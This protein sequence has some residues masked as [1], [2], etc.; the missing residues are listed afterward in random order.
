MNPISQPYA[1][2]IAAAKAAGYSDRE[3]QSFLSQR[4]PRQAMPAPTPPQ[5]QPTRGRGGT[6][7]SLISEGGALSGAALGAS[8]GSAVPIAGTAIGGII[9][10]GVGA[11]GGRIAENKVRDDR[12]GIGDAAK[13]GALSAVLAGPLRLAKYGTT[14]AKAAKSGAGLSQALAAGAD[15]AANFSIRAALGRGAAESGK[16]LA[17]RPLGLAKGQKT[18]VRQLGRGNVADLADKYGIKSFDDIGKTIAAQNDRYGQ[19][20]ES[21][22]AIP[23]K[24]IASSFGE[25]LKKLSG[26]KSTANKTLAQSLKAETDNILKQLPDTID[27]PTLNTIKREFDGLLTPAA[28]MANPAQ[29]NLNK[30]IADA[31]RKGIQKASGSDELR[32]TGLDLR[33][34][35]KLKD[36]ASKNLEAGTGKSGLRLTDIIFG[37]AAVANPAALAGVAGARALSSP[38]AAKVTSTGLKKTGQKLAEK[39]AQAGTVKGVTSSVGRNIAAG[40]ALGAALG[41]QSLE[42]QIMST[43]PTM[44]PSMS[45]PSIDNMPQD[46]NTSQDLSMGGVDNSQGGL[47]SALD[48]NNAAKNIETILSQGGTMKDVNEYIGLITALQKLRPQQSKPQ[49]PFGRPGAQLYSQASTGLQSLSEIERM[50]GADSSLPGKNATPGQ[51]LPGVGG[52]VSRAAGTNEYRAAAY[53]ILNSI[54]RINTGAAMPPSEE[55]FYFRTYLPQPGD[56]PQAIQAKMNNLRAFFEPIAYY[57]QFSNGSDNPQDLLAQLGGAG[58]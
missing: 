56:P 55:A 9:G 43:N 49:A 35:E 58:M 40:S 30:R 52:L 37:G 41:G 27:G 31:L 8:I 20:I 57:D 5:P 53:N 14:A 39:G 46:Y 36:V 16:N 13:E 42:S 1:R 3:I 18:A 29:H 26:S 50:L 10:A 15:D 48:P 33:A 19:I 51:K 22:P 2:Q 44:P 11:F 4:M 45:Q 25:A 54:A 24:D 34:L 21:I 7:T 47:S 23:K 38:T 32:Q 6:L 12:L 17:I 28:Q